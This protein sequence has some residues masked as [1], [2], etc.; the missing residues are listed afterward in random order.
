MKVSGID[1]E[2]NVE[3][4]KQQIE[5]DTTLSPSMRTTLD[6][7]LLIVTLLCQRLG[8]NSRNSRNS[9]K[10]PS[11]DLNRKKEPKNSSGNNSGGQKGHNG[12]TLSLDSTPDILHKLPV[13][14]TL[15]P[16]GYYTEAGYE[17]RQVI[18][19]VFSVL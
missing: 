14:Q 11:T 6:L 3:R 16:K 4:I 10:P 1:I 9:S 8:L 17:T 18:D 12:S 5:G 15:L 2:S 13:D 19:I 7:L